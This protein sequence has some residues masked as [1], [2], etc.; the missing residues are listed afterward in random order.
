MR[1]DCVPMQGKPNGNGCILYTRTLMYELVHN[2]TS[3]LM[4]T[5]PLRQRGTNRTL[6]CSPLTHTLTNSN[7]ASIVSG[8]SNVCQVCWQAA[9]NELAGVYII[10]SGR[11]AA[12]QVEQLG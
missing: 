5:V 1:H 9:A 8:G 4:F 10:F 7:R 12:R 6:T 11:P 2:Q 3:F